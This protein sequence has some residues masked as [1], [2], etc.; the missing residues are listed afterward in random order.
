[1]HNPYAQTTREGFIRF[2]E[3]DAK[4]RIDS[5]ISGAIELAE[6]VHAGLL[7]EDGS[8]PF[9]ESHTWPVAIDVVTHYLTNNRTITSVEIVAA[10]LHDIMEDDERI[11]DLFHSKSYGF[12]AYISYRFGGKIQEIASRLKIPSLDNFQGQTTSEQETARFQSYAEML[13]EADY[14]IKVIKLADRLNNMAFISKIPGHA[15]IRRY[16]REAEDFYIAY[17]MLPPKM[18]GFYNRMRS[19]YEKLR[20]L[21]PVV[22]K[23]I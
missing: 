21:Q 18:T 14:D 20:S 7:R 15:K 5:L 19:E 23:A 9:L 2:L 1:M 10:I 3:H 11:L 8:S 22:T 4:I 16:L 6:E 13:Y 12:D 17:T